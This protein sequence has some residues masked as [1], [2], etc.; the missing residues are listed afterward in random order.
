LPD[1]R[2]AQLQAF[3]FLKELK[4]VRRPQ[5]Y[6]SETQSKIKTILPHVAV[7]FQ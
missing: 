3:S 5:S 6:P 4:L 2:I 7:T 1:D